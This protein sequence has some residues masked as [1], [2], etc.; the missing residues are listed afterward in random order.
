MCGGGN[1]TARGAQSQQV[2]A[3]VLRTA[4]QRGLDATTILTALLTASTPTVPLALRSVP[5]IH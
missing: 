1:R 5:A 3:T 4:D 2:L